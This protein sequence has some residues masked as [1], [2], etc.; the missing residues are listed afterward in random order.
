MCV[1]SLVWIRKMRLKEINFFDDGDAKLGSFRFKICT[2]NSV[3]HC[4]G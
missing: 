3:L 2:F 4:L 1:I